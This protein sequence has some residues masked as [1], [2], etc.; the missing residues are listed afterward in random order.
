MRRS[1][2]LHWDTYIHCDEVAMAT[3]IAGDRLIKD[4]FSCYATV[5]V[6]GE[7]TSGQ[8]VIDALGRLGRSSNVTIVTSINR[9]VLLSLLEDIVK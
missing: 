6:A 5:E 4:S 1:K 2:Y 8:L 3:A 7:L 9:D